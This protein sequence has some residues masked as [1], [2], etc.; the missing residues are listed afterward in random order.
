MRL[1][2]YSTQ[3]SQWMSIILKN[4]CCHDKQSL[5]LNNLDPFFF[6][7]SHNLNII[8]SI[9]DPF[10]SFNEAIKKVIIMKILNSNIETAILWQKVSFSCLHFFPLH[11]F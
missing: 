3:K 2:P 10:R 11:S 8:V 7:P 4:S 1:Q 5:E 6:L 9:N